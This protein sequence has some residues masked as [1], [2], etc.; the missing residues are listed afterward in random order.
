MFHDF[1]DGS[2]IPEILQKDKPAHPG[3][4]ERRVQRRVHHMQQLQRGVHG[5][6]QDGGL[7]QGAAAEIGEVHRHQDVLHRAQQ[8]SLG[9][10]AHG[11]HGA[12]GPAHAL[13]GHAADE[14]RS[15]SATAM[16]PHGDD[17]RVDLRKRDAAAPRKHVRQQYRAGK[18]VEQLGTRAPVPVEVIRFARRPVADYLASLEI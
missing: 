10:L 6:G 4:G 17:V 5:V 15:Q 2:N 13:G 14:H 3:G 11:D 9:L 8:P 1:S 7:A 12:T 16:R 18:R